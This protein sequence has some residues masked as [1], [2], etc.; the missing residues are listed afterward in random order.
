MP[1]VG[2]HILALEETIKELRSRIGNTKYSEDEQRKCTEFASIL[3]QKPEFARLGAIG[4]DLTFFMGTGLE[5]GSRLVDVFSFIKRVTELF[6]GASD[7]ADN[8]DMSDLSQNLEY[9]RDEI[10]DILI[11]FETTTV[12]ALIFVV[13]SFIGNLFGGLG[14]RQE[15]KP[16]QEWKWG[17]I[18]HQH[19][20]GSV[21]KK[22]LHV[23][24]QANRSDWKAYALGYITHLSADISG[25]AYVNQVTGGQPRAFGARHHLCENYIDT[26]AW[27]EMKNKEISG[28]KLHE[29][30]DIGGGLDGFTKMFSEVLKEV[31]DESITPTSDPK[32]ALPVNP[33]DDDIKKAF[34]TLS[35]LLGFIS[36]TKNLL[37]PIPP[38]IQ[39]PPFPGE[40]GTWTS[41]AADALLPDTSGDIS[42]WD[43]LLA[44][45]S[46]TLLLLV[47]I[48]DLIRFII[49]LSIEGGTYPIAAAVFYLQLGLFNIYRFMFL[50]LVVGGVMF[51]FQD[52]LNDWIGE[53]FITSNAPEPH[54][55]HQPEPM[56]EC[57][58]V[59]QLI[60]RA[61][62]YTLLDYHYLTYP[63]TPTEDPPTLSSPYAHE[64]P[65]Y[66][67]N[68]AG[69][70]EQY[71][72][73]SLQAQRPTELD[74][75][76]EDIRN[77][78]FSDPAHPEGKT[79]H[80]AFGSA[81]NIAVDLM[82]RDLPLLDYDI[83]DDRSYSYR[84]WFEPINN[85]PNGVNNT[86][87][88]P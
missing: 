70:S 32:F 37:P 39:I 5:W 17:E 3:E 52:Q 45:L 82:I 2:I 73:K 24:N 20:T 21:A 49:D 28:A 56:E 1:G 46:S 51:P 85:L 7:L 48:A 13:N 87:W 62:S 69:I 10:D 88:S 18:L 55:P 72:T 6:E 47:F 16:L 19:R 9:L 54:F 74:T 59:I 35:R 71:R 27:G 63:R 31:Y 30:I 76:N 57:E 84:C 23:A 68:Q 79:E 53:Q 43:V 75:I 38:P 44:I 41:S 8:L 36:D 34:E 26:F 86:R 22:L 25:H 64:T 65:L 50:F 81:K 11:V 80:L 14:S 66:F 67:I 61:L 33:S 29:K 60:G 4:P 42:I 58:Y 78:M 77:R 12:G 40:A 83:D 15:G